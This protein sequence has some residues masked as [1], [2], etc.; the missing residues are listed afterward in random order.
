M[1]VPEADR[2]GAPAGDGERAER[3]K[4]AAQTSHERRL[5]KGRLS[6]HP[7]RKASTARPP[8]AVAGLGQVGS[9]GPQQKASVE[10]WW[11]F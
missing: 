6:H 2:N 5:A 7:P 1:E 3:T 11:D 10:G 8:P 9:R 4:G